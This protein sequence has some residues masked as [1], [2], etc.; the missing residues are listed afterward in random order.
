MKKTTIRWVIAHEPLSL[1]YR[2]AR[3][4]EKYLNEQQNAESIEIEIIVFLIQYKAFIKQVHC[5]IYNK[6]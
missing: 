3:D 2:A 6:R 5:L 1:F 4:F